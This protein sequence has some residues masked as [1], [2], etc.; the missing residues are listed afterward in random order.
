M[1]AIPCG[2]VG[3]IDVSVLIF[4]GGKSSRWRGSHGGKGQNILSIRPLWEAIGVPVLHG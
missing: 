2:P 4:T 3:I 1:P